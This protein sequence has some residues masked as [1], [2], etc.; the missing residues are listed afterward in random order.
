LKYTDSYDDRQS[1]PDMADEAMQ[2][3][4]IDAGLVEYKDWLKI[5]TDPKE[6]K[7]DLFWFVTKV[8]L[9]PDY[10]VVKEGFIY[11]VEVKGTLKLKQSDYHKLMEMNWRA[12]NYKQVKVGLFYF[13]HPKA[14]PKWFS[15]DKIAELWLDPRTEEGHYPEKDVDGKPKLYKVL[16]AV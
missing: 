2:Q 10:A 5:G 15:A 12:R 7:L 11:L 13:S 14:D 4:L 9:I 3:Y 16:P 1:V 8:L 6:N